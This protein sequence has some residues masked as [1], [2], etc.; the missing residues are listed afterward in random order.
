IIH[1]RIITSMSIR[2]SVIRASD[3]LDERM[4]PIPHHLFHATFFSA[5]LLFATFSSVHF[6]RVT[7]F[8]Y[9]IPSLCMFHNITGFDCPGCG[10]TRAVV[11]ALHGQWYNSY[12]MHMWGIPLAALIAFQVPYHVWRAAGGGTFEVSPQT[13]RWVRHFVVISILIPWAMKTLITLKIILL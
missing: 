11:Y 12:L 4:N 13:K 3:L 5:V 2:A 6:G 7:L 1:L 9:T 8:G 10:I